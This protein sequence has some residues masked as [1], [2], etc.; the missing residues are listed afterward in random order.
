MIKEKHKMF[1]LFIVTT[2]IQPASQPA[3]EPAS[4]SVSRL[5][6]LPP[7]VIQPVSFLIVTCLAYEAASQ[8]MAKSARLSFTLPWLNTKLFSIFS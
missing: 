6:E 1:L 7:A 3:S 8:L 4:Q 5:N 2:V